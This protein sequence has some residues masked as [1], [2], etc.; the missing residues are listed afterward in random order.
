MERN[1]HVGKT[2]KK[3]VIQETFSLLSPRGVQEQ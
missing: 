3:Q 2:S 1:L